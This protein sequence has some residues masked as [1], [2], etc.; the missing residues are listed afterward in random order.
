MVV[1]IVIQKVAAMLITS[2]V[3]GVVV[4]LHAITLVAQMLLQINV[5]NTIQAVMASVQR[6]APKI[7]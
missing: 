4:A 1:T 3:C 2:A 5:K 6:G 7:L